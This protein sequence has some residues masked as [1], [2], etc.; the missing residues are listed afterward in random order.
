MISRFALAVVFLL[1]ALALADSGPDEAP[2][3]SP[4]YEMA[5]F[6]LVFL[7]D[8]NSAEPIPDRQ[9]ARLRTAQDQY[10]RQLVRDGVA[11]IS[12][13]LEGGG[14]I[15]EVAITRFETTLE[16]EAA[17][18]QDPAVLKGTVE[19]EAYTLW[20]AKDILQRPK[21][22][23]ER[24]T[25]HLGLLKRPDRA[26]SFSP[27][28]LKRI[29]AGHL[30]NMDKMAASEDLVIAGPV[31]NGGDLR[32]ILIFRTRDPKRIRALVAE[33]PAV[34]AGRLEMELLEWDIPAGSLPEPSATP[35]P[36]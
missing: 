14:R 12:G 7:V 34:K 27:D 22:P 15:K 26:P 9:V 16:A 29:Q 10:Q 24:T 21:D 4:E 19:A 28:E 8:A 20:A 5:T 11:L 1:P 30:A 6:Q 18:D 31:E 2:A 32:G 25:C 3:E 33:D 17:Y 13:P 36:S 35:D 23:T